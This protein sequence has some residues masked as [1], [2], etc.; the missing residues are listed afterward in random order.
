MGKTA[1]T[2]VRIAPG[3]FLLATL[4]ALLA[5]PAWLWRPL[6]ASWHGHEML[7]GFA[8]AVVCG[9]LVTRPSR[10]LF[11]LLVL[12][13]LAARAAPFL[14]PAPLA[15]WSGLAFPAALLA[16]TVPTLLGSAKRWE[17]RI[18][19]LVLIALALADLVWWAGLLWW[20]AEWQQRAL[21]MAIDLF[22]L[23]LLVFGGR[24]LQSALGGYL[25]RQGIPRRDPVRSGHERPLALLM[26]GAVLSDAFAWPLTAG[27][28]SLAAALTTL[29]RIAPWQLGH[30]LRT[31]RLWSLGLGYLW[32]VAGLALKGMSQLL[33]DVGI[34]TALHGLTIGGLGT[35]TLV[36]MARTAALRARRPIGPFGDMGL[37]V[38][39]LTLAAM[40]RLLAGIAPLP[41]DGLLWLS[42]TGWSLAFL[43]LL[44]RLWADPDQGQGPG[45]C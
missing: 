10:A 14:A 16:A 21:F 27:L 8:L 28:C 26:L 24:A 5:V 34:G 37:A 30:S 41:A 13:W 12:A 43:L 11:A 44:R 40:A 39:L 33:G 6:P 4:H 1:A 17:N 19:P 29:H 22:A 36:M 9:F 7:F 25:E 45:N 38:L 31:A 23:L 42:A 35:L 32:L 18:A 20:G 15:L 3:F 2:P